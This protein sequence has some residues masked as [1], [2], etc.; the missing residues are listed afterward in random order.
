MLETI[1]EFPDVDPEAAMLISGSSSSP[2]KAP[3]SLLQPL[4][5]V[6]LATR[7][8][9]LCLIGVVHCG[10]YCALPPLSNF[11]THCAA[12]CEVPAPVGGFVVVGETAVQYASPSGTSVTTAVDRS[13]FGC[14]GC[15]DPQGAR[16]LLGKIPSRSGWRVIATVVTASVF[17]VAA[18]AVCRGCR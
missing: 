12:T 2:P 8:R 3:S 14:Y 15:V 1:L 16:Y 7:R 11:N 5:G 13:T 4:I 17:N 6:P 18:G 10:E 9:S